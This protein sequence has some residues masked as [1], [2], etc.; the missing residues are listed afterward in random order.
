M[1]GEI[2]GLNLSLQMRVRHKKACE[3]RVAAAEKKWNTG[4]MTTESR[5]KVKVAAEVVQWR[6]SVFP[7]LLHFVN[8]FGIV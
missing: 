1:N 2:H 7:S 3:V 8:G 6:C 5:V 4:Q